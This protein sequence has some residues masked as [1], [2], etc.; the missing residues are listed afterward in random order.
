MR[1][2][3]L[4]LG[5]SE[6]VEVR[7]HGVDFDP[8]PRRRDEVEVRVAGGELLLRWR[9][10]A[11]P[12]KGIDTQRHGELVTLV[13]SRL[14][15]I[16]WVAQA[17]R[18][19]AVLQVHRFNAELRFHEPVA[20]GI[21]DRILDDLRQRYGVGGSLPEVAGWLA[22]RLLLERPD[23]A[24]HRAVISAGPQGGQEAFR[25]F[26]RQIA[27]DI[28]RVGDE[29]RVERVLKSAPR[30]DAPLQLLCAPLSFAD[31][32]AAGK[33]AA[34]ARQALEQAVQDASSYLRIW[35]TYADME[36]EAVL[37]RARSVGTLPY[38][39]C[40]Q[41]RDGGWRFHLAQVEDL[42][43]RLTALGES[44]RYELEAGEAPP[45]WES[46]D[47]EEGRERRKASLAAP[48]EG[49]DR[50]RRIVDLRGPEDEE[51]RPRPPERGFLYLS[52]V[53]D[54]SRL[55]RRDEAE[56][57]LRTGTC[58]MPWLGLLIEGRPA[59]RASY[60]RRSPMS[61]AVKEAFGGSPTQRQLEALDVALNTPDIALIQGPPGTG[62]TKVITAL[63]RRI[64]ELAD[65]GVEPSHRILV[66]ST[67]HDAVETVVQRSEVFGLPA[68]KVGS[69]RG[70]DGGAIDSV[71][72]F[73]AD[74]IERLR[75]AQREP[76]EAERAARARHIAV[77]C[78]RAPVPAA[79]MARHLRALKEV[80]AGL[81]PPELHDRLHR[82]IRELS[83]PT[84]AGDD[85]DEQ[86]LRLAA[87]RG[88]RVEAGAFEDDGPAKA[89][90]ALV[91]LDKMLKPPERDYLERCAAWTEQ[92]APP[93]LAEGV[94]LRDAI[95]DRLQ[96]PA[97]K[98][99]PEL[100]DVT[101]ALLVK[102]IDAI[103][104][105]R[106]QLL[107]G[108]E[109]VLAVYLDDLENDPGAVRQALEHYTVVLA[110]TCQQAASHAMKAVRGINVGSAKF[111]TVIVDEAARANPLDL[112]IPLS[113]ARRRVVLVGDHRQLPH[114][115]EPDV[116]RELSA[117]V[118]RGEIGR[119][120]EE[121][122]K[123]SLFRRLWDLLME[124]QA[125]DT[126]PR[127]VT[128]NTQF[129]M[130]PVLGDFVSRMFYERRGDG[131]ISSG[132]KA[133]DFAHELPG[134][135][136]LGRPCVA[137]WLDVPGGPGRGE[138]RGRS[139]S[140]EPEARRI[141]REVRR[142]IEAA[143]Q[144]T[145][146]V[147]AFYSAQVK[148]IGEA[149]VQEGLAEP[150]D[151]GG[152]R[153]AETWRRTEDARERLRVGTVDAFQGKEFDVVFL[154]ITRSND[155]PGGTDEEQRR[156]YGHLLLENRLCVA[157]SRQHRLLVAVGDQAFIRAAEPL[158]PL[159]DLLLLCEGPHGRIIRA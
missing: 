32:S 72:T 23:L 17:D 20:L 108:D 119:E 8:V 131:Q 66:T 153:I 151:T 69:R 107:H 110:A 105:S 143:P 52:L 130:H 157:M 92:K 97:P 2:D 126:T 3:E 138:R 58:E 7:A 4:H 158:V 112:F 63:Q 39:R 113:M 10:H 146:G 93:W 36:R 89:R 111:E 71:E 49:V 116:E 154:S 141:A 29:L 68:V 50:Q 33:L 70:D 144:L 139:K 19:R 15:I 122:L 59:P 56:R 65:E 80:A 145:F 137:A 5:A 74:R 13:Q 103:E 124:L 73:R 99:Q 44:D 48:L 147:I 102:V 21:D 31:L 109:G 91:R 132:G 42:D 78:L 12:I 104:S 61:P 54:R 24:Y 26:G 84:A 156:K 46:L 100:D 28:Q 14:P 123:K 40:E 37:R 81:I 83:R 135:E 101:Q 57:R 55:K 85:P 1:A 51:E 125:R 149:M 64:A 115:L 129:R 133:E 82:R 95:L 140:R 25:M 76:P 27:I 88:I 106:K 75:A 114:M 98:P 117:A 127:V 11:W 134:Y 60:R 67:Q 35:K 120:A 6:S 30:A 159:R 47:A 41:R 90:K 34:G 148:E 22:E 136:K 128:L 18:T 77:A 62:K 121:S 53:G 79:D 87:A 16:A 152:W 38:E 155:L 86:E 150:T 9:E 96:A 94:P 43:G 142:L 118:E 45:S